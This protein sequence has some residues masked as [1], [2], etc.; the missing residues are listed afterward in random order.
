MID[1]L[2]G[3]WYR[4][5]HARYVDVVAPGG[6]ASFTFDDFPVSALRGAEQLEAHGWRGTFYATPG[7]FGQG[8]NGEH[9][10]TE[11]H[12]AEL[13]R[14]GHEIGNHTTTHPRCQSMSEAELEQQYA[15]SHPVL[16]RYDGNRSFAFPHGA[17]DY[18]SLKFF[19]RRHQSCRTVD[20]GVNR[21]RVDRNRLHGVSLRREQDPAKIE[22][23]IDNVRS[24]GGWVIFYTHD[25]RDQPSAYGITPDRFSALLD[26]VS[27]AG[28]EVVTVA[29]AMDRFEGQRA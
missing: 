25:I 3:W 2:R 26:D 9:V 20:Y 13:A 16:Q 23:I 27:R 28:F 29:E 19:G 1:N 5:V 22:R 17:Y 6:L 24:N 21:G 15:G 14:R 4:R 8:W 10:C 12:L 11:E 7:L 18:T